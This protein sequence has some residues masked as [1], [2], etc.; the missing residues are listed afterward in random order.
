MH[1]IRFRL[2]P[3]PRWGAND[4]S[5]LLAGLAG[6]GATS[7]AKGRQAETGEEVQEGEG[8]GRDGPVTQI[9]GSAAAYCT[10]ALVVTFSLLKLETLYLRA[11]TLKV[12]HFKAGKM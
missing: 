3:G 4:P 5:D 1:Q 2:H 8:R 6:L 9:L 11:T 10:C 7:K 12:L